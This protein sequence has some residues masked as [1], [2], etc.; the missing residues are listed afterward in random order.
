MIV[1]QRSIVSKNCTFIDEKG[2]L[3]QKDLVIKG[4]D[5]YG[6]SRIEDSTAQAFERMKRTK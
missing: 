5:V 3:V 1:N 4:K 2:R 6:Q